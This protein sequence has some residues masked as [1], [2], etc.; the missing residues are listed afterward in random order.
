MSHH[1]TK[2]SLKPPED[3]AKAGP[4]NLKVGTA[5]LAKWRDN[6]EREAIVVERRLIA[7]E[8]PSSAAAAAAA[9]AAAGGGEGSE[10]PTPT[11]LRDTSAYRYYLHWVDFNRRLDSWVSHESVRFDATRNA[12]VEQQARKEKEKAAPA[13]GGEGEGGGAPSAASSSAGAGK[14]APAEAAGGG[15]AVHRKR[16]TPAAAS[17]GDSLVE[18]DEL[19]NVFRGR[20][21]RADGTLVIE[22]VDPDHPE[23]MGEEEIRAHEEVTKV[24]NVNSLQLGRHRMDAWYFSAIPPEFW[25]AGGGG[26]AG[27]RAGTPIALHSAPWLTAPLFFLSPPPLPPKPAGTRAT[28]SPS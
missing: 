11:V 19:G 21:R 20:K 23:H 18:E 13:E 1:G 25:C 28:R 16:T 2:K 14:T 8:A 5:V 6:E 15:A 4:S 7:Q 12:A 3:L 24:K 22:F 27:G 26:R 17:A 10:A 9:A